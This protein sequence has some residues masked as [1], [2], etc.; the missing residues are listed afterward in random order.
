MNS[1]TVVLPVRND[2]PWLRS[3]L[4]RLYAHLGELKGAY[5][6]ELIVVDDAS[7]DSSA[8]VVET[9]RRQHPGALRF[10]RLGRRQGPAAALRAAAEAARS[11]TIVV[12]DGKLSYPPEMIERLV[13]EAFRSGAACVIASAYL[14]GGRVSHVPLLP[15]LGDALANHL[16]SR[17]VRGR[18][19]T[20]T[21]SVRTYETKVLRELLEREPDGEF[22]A[23]MIGELLSAGRMIREVPAHMS[24]P[25][26]RSAGPGQT[27]IRDF[28]R[29]SVGV[30]K[31][32]ARLR[33]L[34]ASSFV[35]AAPATAPVGT[36]GPY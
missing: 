21:G 20:L 31:A 6:T 24:W 27:T 15:R 13:A 22:N 3:S 23:W 12:V 26:L 1:I 28:W 16:L 29:E 11:A 25:A 10:L 5:R 4:E 17:C 8:A 30:L 36:Y 2:G 33:R 18:I 35:S 19:A 32:I 7:Q 9:F 34:P 14:P